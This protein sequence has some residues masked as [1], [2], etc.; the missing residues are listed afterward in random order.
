M[1]GYWSGLT[2]DE[3]RWY[4]RPGVGAGIIPT[5]DGNA[6]VFVSVSPERFQGSRSDWQETLFHQ[7]VRSVD[8]ELADGLTPDRQAASLRAFPGTPGFLKRSWGPG[9]A[10]VGD[11]GYFR[12][13]LTA[14][15][16]TDAFRDAELLARAVGK[17]TD[18]ALREYQA[19]RDSV[20]REF[21]DVTDA[22]ASL[23]WDMDEVKHLHHRLS[24]SMNAC[25]AVIQEWEDRFALTDYVTKGSN[26][27][28][29][30]F[31]AVKAEVPDPDDPTTQVNTGLITTLEEA[32][33]IILAGEALSHCLANTVT[34]IADCFSDPKYIAK[35]VLME[36]ATSP[37]PDPPNTTLFTDLTNKFLA[38]M[39]AKGMQV[40]TTVDFLR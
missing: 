25:M 21:M 19:V 13:P 32:D 2:L 28:T 36:D 38:D 35:L 29:E 1:Y 14:H 20:A 5:N 7:V 17:G 4:F 31:S 8:P 27:W 40:S 23:E 22:I 11:A 16:I 15:G 6:C 39:K 3:Y 33:I 30:H 9:W 34:D 37:V 10:L 18:D 12:D 26:P 24:K